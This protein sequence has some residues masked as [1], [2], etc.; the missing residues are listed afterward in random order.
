MPHILNR[1]RQALEINKYEKI[2]IYPINRRYGELRRTLEKKPMAC[3][4]FYY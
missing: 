1:K 2:H 3:S 4:T